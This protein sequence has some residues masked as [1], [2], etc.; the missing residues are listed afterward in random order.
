MSKNQTP[1]LEEFIINVL[2]ENGIKD[3]TQEQKN[4]YIPEFSLRV[5]RRM[6]DTLISELDD[7]QLDQLSDLLSDPKA[8]PETWYQFWQASID[9]FTKQFMNVLMEFRSDVSSALVA[10]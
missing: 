8:T 1:F 9:D 10:A 6:G 5:Y 4:V 7:K 2:E 3:L